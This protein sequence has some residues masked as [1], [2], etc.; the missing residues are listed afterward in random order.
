MRG[1][2]FM[3]FCIGGN[4]IDVMAAMSRC[5]MRGAKIV[6][7]DYVQTIDSSKRQ[8]DRRNEIRWLCARLKAHAQ[9]LNVHLV[10]LS[11]LSRPPKDDPFREPTKHDLKEAGDIENAAE[12]VLVL[13]RECDDDFAPVRI[14][15]AKSKMGNV[16]CEWQMHRDAGARFVEVDGSFVSSRDKRAGVSR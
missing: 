11:Q 7:V 4:E 12:Y 16:G 10:L 13:W 5:A 15:L 14:K 1:K 3:A 2:M 9:R 6:V 8:Q